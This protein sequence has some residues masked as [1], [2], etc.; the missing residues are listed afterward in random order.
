LAVAVVLENQTSTGGQTAAPIA[1]TLMQALLPPKR[2][3]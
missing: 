3:S 2:R 1:R